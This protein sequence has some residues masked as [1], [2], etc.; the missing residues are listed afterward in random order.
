MT[1]KMFTIFAALNILIGGQT[2]LYAAG[3]FYACTLHYIYGP[4]PPCGALMRPLADKVLSNGKGGT[5]F[6][7]FSA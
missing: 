3:F 6:F 2:R 1:S 4:V 5:V 7:L